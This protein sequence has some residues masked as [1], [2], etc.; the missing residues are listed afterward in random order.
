M[1]HFVVRSANGNLELAGYGFGTSEGTSLA[2]RVC[3]WVGN[4][5]HMA[6]LRMPNLRSDVRIA[7]FIVRRMGLQF[8]QDAFRQVCT[9][10]LLARHLAAAGESPEGILVIG[11]GHGILSAL[12][13]DRFPKARIYLV[14]LG[15]VL[16]FQAV[17]LQKA[18]PEALQFLADEETNREGTAVFHFYPAE[19]ADKLRALTIDV[20]VNI[21]SMQEM[22]PAVIAHYFSVLRSFDSRR[23]FYCCNRLDKHMPGGEVTRFMDYPWSPDDTHYVDELCPWHQWFVGRS[24]SAHVTLWG[25]PMPFV[26][27]FANHAWHRLTRLSGIP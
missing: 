12:L 2:S 16:L 18:F 13:H 22:D 25:V 9:V 15:P 19:S 1:A 6:F 14:D 11:D 7:R 3:S 10:N 26:H 8:S 23:L 4:A 20:A 5:L 27:R 21:A 24:P 17:N